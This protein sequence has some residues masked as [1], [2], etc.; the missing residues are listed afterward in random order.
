MAIKKF[1]KIVKHVHGGKVVGKS[2]GDT[3]SWQS[4]G[5]TSMAGPQFQDPIIG[6]NK[7]EV[8]RMHPDYYLRLREWVRVRDC[9]KGEAVIKAKREIYLP[10]PGGMRGV[11]ASAY[12]SYIDRAHFPLICAYALSSILGVVLTKLPKFNVPKQLEYIL[13]DATRDGRTLNQL[14]VDVIIDIFQTGRVPLLID[15][16]PSLNQ[17]RFVQ[18][19]AENFLNWIENPNVDVRGLVLGVVQEPDVNYPMNLFN[20]ESNQ[21]YK[22]LHLDNDKT[23]QPMFKIS[24]FGENGSDA[25]TTQIVPMYMGKPLQE[26]PLF[27]A[28]S[29]NNS[30]E[31]Q[32]IPMISV[33]NCAVQIYRKEAD[34]SNSEF[35]SCNPTLVVTGAINDGTLPNVVGSS[36]MIVIPNEQGR[37]YYTTTD[38]AALTHV[39]DHIQD[40]Y[41]EAIRHGAAILAPHKG[42]EAAEALRIRMATQSASLY[43]VYLSA[44]TAITKALKLMC[45]WAGYD[46]DLVTVDAPTSLTFGIP[47][48]NVMAQIINGYAISGVV[49]V[50]VVHNYVVASGLVDQSVSL[51][52]YKK[53]LMDSKKFKS[54]LN[55][56]GE[57]PT[58]DKG[59]KGVS[60]GVNSLNPPDGSKPVDKT[61][62]SMPDPV[63]E[64]NMGGNQD[65]N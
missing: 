54:K 45:K 11:Y 48:A 38:T 2:V 9:M 19:K 49:P 32:P 3:P 53:M 10:R 43:S 8:S 60:N 4:A 26:I 6:Y 56:E 63:V 15:I 23:N 24:V 61:R 20:Y 21:I 28:G 39:K 18:Y 5:E 57:V 51:D 40:L 55:P 30:F 12:D 46:E 29:I 44:Q 35:L 16:V 41:D 25:C 7:S 13:E 27:I 1:Q 36:V 22:V 65:G 17:F 42:V 62:T 50:D 58:P 14:F 52:D 64:G 47:D 59:V 33:A 31:V 34:L 37:V